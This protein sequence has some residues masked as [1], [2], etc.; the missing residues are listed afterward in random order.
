MPIDDRDLHDI[1]AEEKSRGTRHQQKALTRKQ[2]RKMELFVRMLSDSNCEERE[3]LDAIRD[4]GPKDGEPEFL[5]L[6]N[7]WKQYR[8]GKP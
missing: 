2:R 5:R 4:L 8:G 6:W 1:M 7:L 3:V